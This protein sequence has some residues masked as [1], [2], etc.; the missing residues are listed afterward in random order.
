MSRIAAK[1]KQDR[2]FTPEEAAEIIMSKIL[3]PSSS[4]VGSTSNVREKLCDIWLRLKK[5]K[6]TPQAEHFSQDD[7]VS[8]L[9]DE[10]FGK[11]FSHRFLDRVKFGRGAEIARDLELLKDQFEEARIESEEKEAD[12]LMWPDFSSNFATADYAPSTSIPPAPIPSMYPPHPQS[13]IA[14]PHYSRSPHVPQQMAFYGQMGYQ[15]HLPSPSSVPHQMMST[16]SSMGY[17]P[18]SIMPHIVSHQPMASSYHPGYP[19]SLHP[20]YVRQMMAASYPTVYAGPPHYPLHYPSSL[21]VDYASYVEQFRSHPST[22]A[23]AARV[24]PFVAKLIRLQRNQNTMSAS[25]PLQQS[26]FSVPLQYSSN[27]VPTIRTSPFIAKLIRL[28]CTPY[29][30]TYP[31][32]DPKPF[33]RRRKSVPQ[34]ILLH[35]LQ[36]YIHNCISEHE[37]RP[38]EL[39]KFR[40]ISCAWNRAVVDSQQHLPIVITSY[41]CGV[42]FLM[43]Q[44]Y[45]TYVMG[46]KGYGNLSVDTENNC[47]RLYLVVSGKTDRTGYDWTTLIHLLVHF[48]PVKQLTVADL[49]LRM[50]HVA[51]WLS[52]GR[53]TL[54]SLKFTSTV[55][56]DN[57]LGQDA[58]SL[59]RPVHSLASLTVGM[60]RQHVPKS[61]LHM[62]NDSLKQLRVLSGPTTKFPS[63]CTELRSLVIPNGRIGLHDEYVENDGVVVKAPNLQRLYV[64]AAGWKRGPMPNGWAVGATPP[65]DTPSRSLRQLVKEENTPRLKELCVF[66]ARWDEFDILK[67]VGRSLEKDASGKKR[68]KPDGWE[69]LVG[70]VRQ[71]DGKLKRLGLSVETFIPLKVIEKCGT[72]LER[73]ELVIARTGASYVSSREDLGKHLEMKKREMVVADV[74]MTKGGQAVVT[75]EEVRKMGR[76]GARLFVGYE[77]KRG[78]GVRSLRDEVYGAYAWRIVG[79]GRV[80]GRDDDWEKGV[81]EGYWK[82]VVKWRCLGGDRFLEGV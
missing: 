3:H 59:L 16:F 14:S 46:R 65:M 81:D 79:G 55:Q 8:R 48:L 32:T 61:L 37:T 29:T 31:P 53:N 72:S 62:M 33:V 50:T 58:A 69:E 20:Q 75:K 40:E 26:S 51:R 60:A 42:A 4:T 25:V 78:G 36:F 49:H 30:P 27:I 39:M 9:W 10:P 77:G 82:E 76:D 52:S 80:P 19:Q 23:P 71:C 12:F 11:R 74:Q 2:K 22:A 18:Y 56:F 63:H 47:P 17:Q 34:E 57:D 15:E 5:L 38:K 43:H 1:R 54:K 67:S 70:Y 68:A 73:F 35:I 45:H 41:S 28:G 13:L 7:L 6:S 66:G 21:Y 24:S 64:V 44:V